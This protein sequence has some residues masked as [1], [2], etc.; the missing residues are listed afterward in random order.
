[1]SIDA[2]KLLVKIRNRPGGKSL[3]VF[4]KWCET[5]AR[6]LNH[7]SLL[8]FNVETVANVESD[9][10]NGL[11]FP[12]ESETV[13]L[14]RNILNRF[15]DHDEAENLYVNMNAEDPHDFDNDDEMDIP[16]QE[17]VRE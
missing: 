12:Y 1:M 17:K 5:R 14:A 6:Q 10:A 3:T 9:F 16:S 11:E 4:N 7:V 8:N 2:H 13:E 15:V